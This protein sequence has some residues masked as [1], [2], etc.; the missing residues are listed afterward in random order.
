MIKSH[1]LPTMYEVELPGEGVEADPFQVATN[2]EGRE[3]LF[4]QLASLAGFGEHDYKVRLLRPQE[5]DKISKAN[6]KLARAENRAN[7]WKDVI[8]KSSERIGA[9][10]PH[11]LLS[12]M[13]REEAEITVNLERKGHRTDGN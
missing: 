8:H 3:V 5:V 9:D 7:L 11:D 6:A 4:M 10:A 1:C 12:M 2:F 13:M